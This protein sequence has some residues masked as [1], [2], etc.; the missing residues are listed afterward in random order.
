M[1]N[2]YLI[3]MMAYQAGNEY[4]GALHLESV[5]KPLCYKYYGALHLE[6]VDKLLCYKYF[7]AL[8]L[9][10]YGPN[11]SATN[12]AVLCTFIL[13]G[14]FCQLNIPV[15][16]TLDLGVEVSGKYR[17]SNLDS[18][19]IALYNWFCLLFVQEGISNYIFLFRN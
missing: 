14:L 11:L 8:H 16:R 5:V 2:F 18:L 9:E 17:S 4:F 10:S 15:L 3:S 12:I 6:S 7:G 19:F 1:M 13:M